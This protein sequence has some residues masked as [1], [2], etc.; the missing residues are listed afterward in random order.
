ML[1]LH[2]LFCKS[3]QLGIEYYYFYYHN[4]YLR[5]Q[6]TDT[7]PYWTFIKNHHR[8]TNKSNVHKQVL[9]HI[10]QREIK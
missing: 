5:W 3:L 2:F 10:P 8:L 9:F 4:F 7:I 6:N 1:R